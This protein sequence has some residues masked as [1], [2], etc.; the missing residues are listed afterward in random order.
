MSDLLGG[1]PEIVQ[2]ALEEKLG[3][4]LITGLRELVE[5]P[6]ESLRMFGLQLAHSATVATFRGDTEWLNEIKGQVDLMLEINRLKI[7]KKN[8]KLLM[9]FLQFGL[10]MMIKTALSVGTNFLT[11]NV[12]NLVGR[13]K[14]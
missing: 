2:A 3:T 6:E 7:T 4:L 11:N 12:E 9:S 8:R 10:E 5:G 14:A 1:I 13:I